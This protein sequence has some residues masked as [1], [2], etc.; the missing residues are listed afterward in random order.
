VGP[1]FTL[2]SWALSHLVY[3][4]I[5][6]QPDDGLNVVSG[7]VERRKPS[8]LDVAYTVLANDQT[9]PDLVARITNTNGV[10]WRDGLPYQQNLAAARDVIDSQA[11]P[12]WQESLY[13]AWLAALR[14]LSAPTTDPQ[15]PEA[16]R[17]RPW[18]MKTLNTQ[19]ASWTQLR[20]DAI[21]YAASSYT[22]VD[23]CGYPAGFV[24]PRPEFWSQMQALADLAATNLAA[25]PASG[26][27]ELPSRAPGWGGG[28]GW[29][30][31]DLATVQSNQVACL[32]SFAAQMATLQDIAEKELAQQPLSAAGT[33]FLQNLIE[34]VEDY[35][36]SQRQF[37][38]W[39]PRLIYRPAYYSYQG[40]TNLMGTFEQ[41]VGSDMWD[42][43][44]VDVATDLPDEI[45][46]DP[47]AVIHDAVGSVNMLLIAVDN[48]ADRMAFAGPVLSHYELEVPGV[49]RLSNA[50]WQAM[51]QAGTEPSPPEWTGSYLV[52]GPVAIPGQN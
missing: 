20:Q 10:Q 12:V 9:V 46:G 26:G 40:T 23:L 15:Y 8:C 42:A 44:I 36:P 17:T 52:P 37:N 38:G 3:D 4:R 14:A 49:N 1:K 33:S 41:D 18:A 29:C 51:L 13:T 19:M 34:I 39:Y 22:A 6:W 47:G 32:T 25:V 48:G 2:D 45:V 50:D 5:A 43:L 21:L 35:I 30:Y 27:I 31:Y 11:D 24:E 16:T 28:P 7:K